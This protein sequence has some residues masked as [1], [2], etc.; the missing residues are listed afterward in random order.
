MGFEGYKV[1]P[2]DLISIH[3]EDLG[4]IADLTGKDFALGAPNWT[5][6]FGV[7]DVVT[8]DVG[9]K[10][11]IEMTVEYPNKGEIVTKYKVVLGIY[12]KVNK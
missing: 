10:R 8:T 11:I 3:D 2:Q 4:H 5:G 1:N 7:G 6:E 9:E 12:P